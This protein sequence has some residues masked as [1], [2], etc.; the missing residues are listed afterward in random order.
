MMTHNSPAALYVAGDTTHHLFETV[1]W[2]VLP[3]HLHAIWT[4]P[5]QDCDSAIRWMLIE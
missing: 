2:A 1:A 3:Q 4:L 5:E